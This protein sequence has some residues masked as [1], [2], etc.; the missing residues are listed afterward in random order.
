LCCAFCTMGAAGVIRRSEAKSSWRIN[1]STPPVQ[2]EFRQ[3]YFTILTVD[4]TWLHH[5]DPE[6][7][8][9]SMA[10]KHVY[11][12]PIIKFR[13]V[14]SSRTVMVTVFWDAEVASRDAVSPEQR[15]CS[16]VISSTGCHPKCRI[17]TT[18]SPTIFAILGPKRLICF[19]NGRNS[20]KDANL[21]TT[22]TL[23]ANGWLELGRP[24]STI[25]LQRNP[26]FGETLNQVHFSWRRLLK[27]TKYDVHIL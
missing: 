15:T 10:W 17:R 20:W 9:Q 19:L 21:L 16:Y 13:V 7:K 3:L 6:S 27:V 12:P 18:P 11:S 22:R 23:S 5:F 25:L 14:A 2:R 1:K 4:E 24:R 26:S 8:M